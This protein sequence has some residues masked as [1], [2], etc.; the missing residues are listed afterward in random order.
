MNKIFV[1]FRFLLKFNER[2]ICFYFLFS[3]VLLFSLDKRKKKN[4]EQSNCSIR[5]CCLLIFIIICEWEK[6]KSEKPSYFTPKRI[7]KNK[8]KEE[9]FS[10]CCSGIW[11]TGSY[12]STK[13][14]VCCWIAKKWSMFDR[15]GNV[16][17]VER[18]WD[19]MMENK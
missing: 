15:N 3:T 10:F 6:I 5:C 2:K 17:G 12:D 19:L 4:E 14:I 16:T 7:P 8:V 18:E 1:W 9:C 11:I 13:N